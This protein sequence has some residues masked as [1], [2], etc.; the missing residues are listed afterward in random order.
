MPT[1]SRILYPMA[2]VY[3]PGKAEEREPTQENPRPGGSDTGDVSSCRWEG[4]TPM[5]LVERVASMAEAKTTPKQ[6]RVLSEN[7][8]DL[9]RLC[10]KEDYADMADYKKK[11]S[12]TGPDAP[13]PPGGGNVPSGHCVPPVPQLMF[14]PLWDTFFIVQVDPD[15][16]RAHDVA[17]KLRQLAVAIESAPN[18]REV[19]P[20]YKRARDE[21]SGSVHWAWSHHRADPP[22]MLR[23]ALENFYS[24]TL[25]K[26]DVLSTMATEAIVPPKAADEAASARA[27]KRA[28]K[29]SKAAR[30]RSKK[31][32]F[33]EYMQN[34]LRA[35]WINPYPDDEGLSGLADDCETTTTV[36]SNWLINARTRKWRPAIVKAYE[37]RRPAD[38]LQEDAINIFDGKPV[39]NLDCGECMPSLPVLA[40][41]KSR[42]TK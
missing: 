22:A 35:N 36:V 12:R 2:T 11:R 3:P 10:L 37:M 31:K 23:F 19:L 13:P 4:F 38:L 30:G 33:A 34:W 27:S 16:V 9:S 40:S 24:K 29:S 25:Q 28:A 26:L 5:E 32:D 15:P 39:R 20:S 14:L 42:V 1:K 41:D 21:F 8:V 6:K 17:S 7:A 18:Y